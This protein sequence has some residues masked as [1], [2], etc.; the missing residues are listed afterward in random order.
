VE[1]EAP[2]TR[3]NKMSKDK[4]IVKDNSLAEWQKK[5]EADLNTMAERC[6]EKR[7]LQINSD[8]PEFVDLNKEKKGTK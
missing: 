1:G 6:F 4:K 2:P 8:K 3:E 7:Y 5:V